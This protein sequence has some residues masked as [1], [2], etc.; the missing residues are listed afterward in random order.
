QSGGDR[1]FAYPP[2][3]RLRIYRARRRS[4]EAARSGRVRRA[5]LHREAGTRGSETISGL[6]RVFL[7]RGNV[8]LARVHLLGQLAALPACHA[9]G[10]EGA[11]EGW[12]HAALS[13]S[14]PPRL[15]KAPEYFG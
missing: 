8:F 5:T 7:E 1:H 14:A 9:R 10:H 4:C 13:I 11:R 12:R 2:G 15:S 6:R 3:N